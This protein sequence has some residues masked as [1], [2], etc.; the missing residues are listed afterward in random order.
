MKF[1]DDDVFDPELYLYFY[2]D[3]IS[4]AATLRQCH[5][6]KNVLK[7]KTG[8]KILDV[9]CGHGR[10]AAIFS[11]EGN[12]VTGIDSNSSFIK[13]AKN[14]FSSGHQNPEYYCMDMREVNF[15]DKF[16]LALLLFSS[17][18]YY[19]DEEN[20]QILAA[21][22]KSLKLGGYFCLDVMNK[23]NKISTLPANTILEKEHNMMVDQAS[24]NSLSKR[25]ETKRIYIKDNIVT[26]CQYSIR[27]YN[28][29]ELVEL[30]SK[31]NLV[32]EHAYGNWEG[33]D[34]SNELGRIIL[35][36]RKV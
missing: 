16:E 12:D 32:V 24:Y 20:E 4:E 8:T 28:F 23:D 15:S 18:G 26:R 14:H 25:I 34:V 1:V 29:T 6:I 27:V 35:F 11:R 31:N 30:C 17:F 10:H 2:E 5:F 21:I 3:S 19:S 36:A 22:S 7:L 13:L 33:D 9:A